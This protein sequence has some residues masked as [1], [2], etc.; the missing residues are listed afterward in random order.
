[1]ADS[2]TEVAVLGAGSWGTALAKHLADQGHPTKLWSRRP[3]QAAHIQAHRTNPD[4]LNGVELPPTL[5][6]TA[7]LEEA[8]AGARTVVVVVPTEGNRPLLEQLAPL[9]PEGVPVVSATKGIEQG[10]LMLVSEIFED[11]FRAERH[12]ALTYL[13]GPSFAREVAAGVPTA[14][15]VAGHD[16]AMRTRVQELFNTP[17]FRVY[18]TPD[19]IGVEVGGALKNVI[20][21]AAGVA[22]G[23]GLG[24]NTRAALIT[25]G[26]AELSR[27]AMKLGADPLTLAGL[28]GMGDLVL[29]CTGDLSR[30]R[31]VG[32]GLG[33]GQ[34]L[35]EILD[36]LGMVAEGVKTAK[37]AH[38]LATRRDV[39]MPI[40]DEIHAILYEDKPAREALVA[41]MTRPLKDERE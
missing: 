31:R 36:E 6:A 19:V 39:E 40:T 20:A 9:V 23:M 17:R 5:S 14:V 3:E 29:T 32:M 22:D 27:L 37:S 25:R 16:E 15:S 13:G 26:L 41:L 33:R 12:G 18:T 10:T 28:S 4:Y 24:H 8:V 21:I 30:N 7:D 11:V 34:K 1:M 2:T 35:A 38:E